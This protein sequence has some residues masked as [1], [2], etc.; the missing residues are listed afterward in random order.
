MDST[1]A[2]VKARRWTA[3]GCKGT[4]RTCHPE[5]SEAVSPSGLDRP[6]R[7]GNL[8]PFKFALHHRHRPP[9]LLAFQGY[10]RLA[11]L[12]A[13]GNWQLATGNWQLATGN[14]S[15]SAAEEELVIKGGLQ[16]QRSDPRFL[17]L[18]RACVTTCHLASGSSAAV[19]FFSRSHSV[20][21]LSLGT[22][23]SELSTPRRCTHV[24]V[25][26]P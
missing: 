5:R 26:D 24:G 2:E 6:A 19:L 11:R 15:A 12:L 25:H 7:F 18:H 22:R 4:S 21:R 1:G 14:C 3:G 8:S 13:T 10:R 23:N 16:R 9:N 20:I 17:P